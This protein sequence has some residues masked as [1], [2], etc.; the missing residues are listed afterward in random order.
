MIRSDQWF[1]SIGLRHLSIVSTVR[2]NTSQDTQYLYHSALKTCSPQFFSH[3][4]ISTMKLMVNK[5]YNCLEPFTAI[6]D[7]VN[8]L[9][10]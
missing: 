2:E 8:T 5:H 7:E 4:S 1:K 3:F 9:I 6:K 10:D